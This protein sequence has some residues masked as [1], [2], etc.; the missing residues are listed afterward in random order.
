MELTPRGQAIF[1]EIKDHCIKE[2]GFKSIDYYGLELLAQA[3]DTY[4]IC[5]DI[6]I[7]KG[8]TQAAPRT[9]FLV[10]RP[11]VGIQKS[12]GELITKLSDRFGLSPE[13]R[14]KIFG[15]L[16]ERKEKKKFDLRPLRSTSE[17]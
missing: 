13:S 15:K 7:E 2:L 17:N 8:L 16:P 11:E 4:A 12:A 5:N 3:F 6:L 1:E 9:G 10:V 14:K